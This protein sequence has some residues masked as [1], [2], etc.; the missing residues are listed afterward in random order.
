MLRRRQVRIRP[1]VHACPGELPEESQP[2]QSAHRT[3]AR[4]GTLQANAPVAT[5]TNW[6]AAQL[7]HELQVHQIELEMHNEELR[8]SYAEA[9]DLREKYADI[10]D[11]APV[12]YFTLNAQGVILQLNL[13]GA[14]L[15]GIKRSQNMRHRFAAAVNP[16]YLPMF[17]H[18]FDE[19]LRNKSKKSCEMLLLPTSHNPEAFVRIQAVPGESG[20]ECRMVVMDITAEKLAEK[21]L[22]LR[23]QYLRTVL[24][25]FPFL[26]WLKD[27]QS[28]F[29][30]VN[31]PFA[32]NF[33]WPSPI[34]CAAKPTSTLPPANWR[35]IIAPAIRPYSPAARRQTLKN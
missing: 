19:V 28:R 23:E 12:A 21:A 5:N 3:P 26:V 13:A 24:N 35:N 34:R 7:L 14:I 11:F 32:E 27:E 25:N 6:E 33:G 10:Y 22:N 16:E 20:E 2:P 31:A 30:A 18:F 8:N 1:L 4:R 17:Q 9:D 15:L 29:L